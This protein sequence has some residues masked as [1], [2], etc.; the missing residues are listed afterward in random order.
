ML[1]GVSLGGQPAFLFVLV[2]QAHATAPPLEFS[3]R[4][5]TTT[6]ALEMMDDGSSFM[7]KVDEWFEGEPEPR[8]I[9]TEERP[10]PQEITGCHFVGP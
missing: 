9:D 2:G 8:E 7:I 3:L 1:C 4:V 10:Y 5:P 6:L